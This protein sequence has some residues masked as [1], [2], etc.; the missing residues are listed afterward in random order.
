MVCVLFTWLNKYIAKCLLPLWLIT[1]ST[2]FLG[3]KS[4]GTFKTSMLFPA[5]SLC[6]TPQFVLSIE[7]FL[8]GSQMMS[9]SNILKCFI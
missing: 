4:P 9:G 7:G 1:V 5:D 6:F 2:L 8:Y 3:S